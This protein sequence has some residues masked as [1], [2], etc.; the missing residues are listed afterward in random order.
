M[1]ELGEKTAFLL[2]TTTARLEEARLHESHKNE[3]KYLLSAVVKRNHLNIDD[4]L[5]DNARS[6]ALTG[7]YGLS[8]QTRQVIRAYYEQVEKGLD[9]L[10]EAPVTSSN[11]AGNSSTNN[12]SSLSNSEK[13]GGSEANTEIATPP[14]TY[15]ASI[16]SQS[17]A[18]AEEEPPSRCLAERIM[19]VRKMKQNMGRT[20]LMLSGGG[21][22]AMYHTG[23]IRSLIE[24]KLYDGIK[25]VSGRTGQYHSGGMFMRRA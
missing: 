14:A 5:V 10:A 2:I 16:H 22:Q 20:A 25:V 23:L 19:L 12:I 21:A 7:Q 8:A 13:R 6:I 18:V 3:L 15:Y 9:W 17:S 4:V 1:E 24:S 11:S